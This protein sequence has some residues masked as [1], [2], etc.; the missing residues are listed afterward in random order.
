MSCAEYHIIFIFLTLLDYFYIN[1]LIIFNIQLFYFI[2]EN[3]DGVLKGEDIVVF[4]TLV[5][6]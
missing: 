2:P 5:G 6:K 4:L 1:S 3:N